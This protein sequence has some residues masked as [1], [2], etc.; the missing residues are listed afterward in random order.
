MA[1]TI[2]R[3]KIIINEKFGEKMN[4]WINAKEN[5]PNKTQKVIMVCKNGD[6]FCGVAIAHENWIDWQIIG[7]KG[8]I[9][10]GRQPTH[11]MPA[12]TPPSIEN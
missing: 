1:K 12:P 8:R 6:M 3:R 5:P 10:R 7:A 4:E 2:L 11:W 9:M